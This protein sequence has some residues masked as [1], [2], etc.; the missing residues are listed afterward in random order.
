MYIITEQSKHDEIIEIYENISSDFV[1]D[2]M[3]IDKISK[4]LDYINY[5][6]YDYGTF[7]VVCSYNNRYSVIKYLLENDANPNIT[8][9]KISPLNYAASNGY[10]DIVKIL[11]KY[12][13][14]INDVDNNNE[15]SIISAAMNSGTNVILYLL[16]KGASW[17]RD[18]SNNFFIDYLNKFNTN[19][20]KLIDE[21]K[22]LYPEEYK[23]YLKIKKSEKFN[24]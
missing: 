13:A 23:K 19:E 11:L 5:D 14:N 2:D 6:N 24:L 12:G 20:K 18:N 9:D 10:L 4:N 8:H 15:T 21:I 22:N 7:L 17:T 1:S 3:I 16:E